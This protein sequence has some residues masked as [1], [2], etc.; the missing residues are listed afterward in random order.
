[1]GR[2][3][4]LEPKNPQKMG[5]ISLLDVYE[6]ATAREVNFLLTIS[7]VFQTFSNCFFKTEDIVEYL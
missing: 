6:W 7:D 3:L 5:T 1:M 2:V 4:S